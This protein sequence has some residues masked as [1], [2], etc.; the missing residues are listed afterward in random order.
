MQEFIADKEIVEFSEH[1]FIHQKTPYLTVLLSYRTIDQDGKKRPFQGEEPRK[2]L[3]EREKETYDALRV[4][5]LERAKQEG[6]PPYMIANNKQ[7][8]MMIKIRALTITDLARIKSFGEA[9]TSR[10]G[11]DILRILE[12]HLKL[13]PDNMPAYEKESH[14]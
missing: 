5:R 2:D 11:I 12:G 3:D 13:G 8:A 6:I 10:Y 4:W 1:F 9:K 7:L 14:P